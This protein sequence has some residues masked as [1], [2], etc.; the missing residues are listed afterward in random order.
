M[1]QPQNYQIIGV[2]ENCGNA[3]VGL[4]SVQVVEVMLA[5]GRLGSMVNVV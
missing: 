3:L 4:R 2:T 1:P 5:S